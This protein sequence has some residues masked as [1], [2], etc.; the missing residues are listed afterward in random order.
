MELPA[1]LSCLSDDVS[2]QSEGTGRGA[3]PLLFVL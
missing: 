1:S 3:R 2:G